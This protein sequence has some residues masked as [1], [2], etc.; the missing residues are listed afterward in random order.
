MA[1]MFHWKQPRMEVPLQLLQTIDGLFWVS[2]NLC[3]N[4]PHLTT[5][6]FFL[7]LL[8]LIFLGAGGEILLALCSYIL[9][10]FQVR[11]ICSYAMTNLFTPCM[12]LIS[13]GSNA[14]LS[15][16][17]TVVTSC[18][19]VSGLSAQQKWYSLRVFITLFS[20]SYFMSLCLRLLIFPIFF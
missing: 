3:C 2:N 20:F 10:I 19:L 18:C 17:Q 4:R 12:Y 16:E 5:F 7:S 9:T 6:F 14:D 1:P 8:A 15:D 11:H 13:S